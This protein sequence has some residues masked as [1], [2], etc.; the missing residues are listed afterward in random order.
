M[1]KYQEVLDYINTFIC[2]K[3]E[4]PATE[5]GMPCK[6]CNDIEKVYLL[7]QLVDRET[8]KKVNYSY[9]GYADGI[10]VYDTECPGCGRSFDVLE[11][12]DYKYC[13]FCGQRLNWKGL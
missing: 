3:C 7:Q 1:N 13:P 8:P 10:P 5:K 9:D 6:K 4:K 2:C 11:E 12:E